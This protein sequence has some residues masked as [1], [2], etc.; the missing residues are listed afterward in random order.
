MRTIQIRTLKIQ[1][2]NTMKTRTQLLTQKPPQTLKVI[3]QMKRMPKARTFK[4][5]DLK[6]KRKRVSVGMRWKDRRSSK[7]AE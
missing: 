6:K 5:M 7:I 1:T 3:F 4:E 2:L